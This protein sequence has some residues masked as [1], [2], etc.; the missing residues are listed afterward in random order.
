MPFNVP[1]EEK[2]AFNKKVQESL[3]LLAQDI[4]DTLGRVKSLQPQ[5]LVDAYNQP[6]QAPV[7]DQ[8]GGDMEGIVRDDDGN[9]W[10]IDEYRPAIYYFD[11]TGRLNE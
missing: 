9:Y 3:G 7:Q 8:L 2:P 6:V 5:T 4:G 1:E 10:M 11:A